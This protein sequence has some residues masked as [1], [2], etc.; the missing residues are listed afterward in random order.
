MTD[1][2]S[3]AIDAVRAEGGIVRSTTL[4]RAGVSKHVVADAVRRGGLLRLRRVWVAIPEADPYL[5]SAARNGVVVSCVT[6]AQR[7]D[8]WSIDVDQ[9]HV[10]APAHAGMVSLDTA[11]VHRH[12]P[13]IPR[14]PDALEDPI[15][16]ALALVAVCQPFEH[17]L[18]IFDSAFR[19]DLVDPSAFSRYTLSGRAREL[20]AASSRY[21]DSGLETIVYV[22][23]RFLRLPIVSQV[24]LAGHRV[25][26]LIGDRL[27]LQIDGGHHVGRQRA[28]DIEHD[29]RLALLGYHVIRV[30]Y[31]QVMG[32]WHTVLDLVVRAIGQGRHLAA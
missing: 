18:A 11:V 32:R 26:F 20:L 29:A 9:P 16:N 14:H 28:D 7:L 25:D 31:E 24:W 23:L 27:V 4:Q 22:R 3:H 10:A 15:E 12:Q 2:V 1:A 17:A 21:R 19:K 6:R 5:L 8:L 13:L 30:T